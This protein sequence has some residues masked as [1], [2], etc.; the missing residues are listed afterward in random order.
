[1]TPT[2]PVNKCGKQPNLQAKGED[3]RQQMHVHIHSFPMVE[4]HYGLAKATKGRK[5]LSLSL[6]T[7]V[8]HKLYLQKYEP[9]VVARLVQGEE[10]SPVVMYKYY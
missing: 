4:S 1:M 5:F 9:N 10:A 7:A 6:S 3:V 8:M 2:P